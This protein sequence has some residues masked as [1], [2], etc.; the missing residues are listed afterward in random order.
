MFD[1]LGESLR[2]VVEEEGQLPELRARLLFRQLVS[3]VAHCHECQ[4]V[5]R[6]IKLDKLFLNEAGCVCIADLSESQL[7]PGPSALLLD[8]KGSPAYV[9]PEVLRGVPYDGTAADMWSVGVVLYVLLC[10]RFPFVASSPNDLM[11]LAHKIQR[12][13]VAF[14][15]NVSGPARTLLR[16]LLCSDPDSRPTA[17]AVL[18]DPFMS[19]GAPA[20]MLS[21]ARRHSTEKRA[22]SA[23]PTEVNG[24]D[25]ADDQVVPE[26]TDESDESET[27][28]RKVARSK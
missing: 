27:K 13:E 17:A 1:R 12:A 10:G 23:I 11:S 2:E 4:I 8:Q 6:D 25:D 15:E 14:P 22:R 18:S 20:N 24:V 19:A 5:L 9:A 26:W 3:A 7:L 28:R 16:R 21:P